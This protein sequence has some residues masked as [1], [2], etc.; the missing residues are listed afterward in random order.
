MKKKMQRLFS[1]YRWMPVLVTAL[2]LLPWVLLAEGDPWVLIPAAFCLLLSLLFGSSYTMMLMNSTVKM[3]QDH[4]DPHPLLEE[5]TCQLGYVKNRSDRTL[6]TLNRAAGL[7]EAG[8]YGQALEEL[9][10]LD[11]HDPVVIAPWRYVY[12]H[13]LTVAAIECGQKEKAEVYYR[14]ALQQFQEL[15]GKNR[16]KIHPQ[17]VALSAEICLM[18]ENYAQACELLAPLTPDALKAHVNRA[19]TLARIAA[20]QG[21]PEA[22]RMHLDFVL[23]YGN[24]LHVVAKAQ[25]LAEELYEKAPSE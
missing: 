3:L 17:R 11:I 8:Y 12:Y 14:N 13:N 1:R 22:A 19:Y 16:E 18:Y 20:A 2:M 25:K 21:Q 7:I 6:L 9:E 10:A 4:C 23:R 5:T 24:R 15:K